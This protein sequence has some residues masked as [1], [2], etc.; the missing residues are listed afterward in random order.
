[1]E[2]ASKAM[3]GPVQ[4]ACF[5]IGSALCGID[6]NAIQEMNRQ[7][8]M[9]RVPQAPAYVLGIMNLRGRIVT[10]IDLGRKLGLA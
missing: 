1:M 2:H 10:I 9:T 4:L 6:I 8:E 5:F 3:T 7:L